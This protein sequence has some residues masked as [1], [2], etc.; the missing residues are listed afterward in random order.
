MRKRTMLGVAVFAIIATA[1]LAQV[2]KINLREEGI[3]RANERD[4]QRLV[5]VEQR[6]QALDIERTEILA[7]MTQRAEAKSG[8][9]EARLALDDQPSTL[10][11]LRDVEETP[12][13]TR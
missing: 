9:A 4:A 12:G 2:S 6:M 5:V 13:G 11:V 7:R 3:D 1:A 10:T 8:F